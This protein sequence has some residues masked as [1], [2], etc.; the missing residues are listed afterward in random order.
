M[1]LRV[2]RHPRGHVASCNG[3][4]HAV[5]VRIDHCSRQPIS[6]TELASFAETATVKENELRAAKLAH[7]QERVKSR[8]HNREKAKQ[9]EMAV[10]SRK[11][12]QLEQRVTDQAVDGDRI[13]VGREIL[14]SVCVSC[15]YNLQVYKS[16]DVAPDVE[17][18]RVMASARQHAMARQSLS[19]Q[20]ARRSLLE[21][22][23]A[24]GGVTPGED[25]SQSEFR[26]LGQEE[27]VKTVN[28]PSVPGSQDQHC[29]SAV[30]KFT[31]PMQI[32]LARKKQA[33]MQYLVF[34]RLYS[35]LEREQT[36]QRLLRK[37]HYK[38]V[39][40]LKR[41]KEASRRAVEDEADPMDSFSTVSSD[42]LGDEQKAEEWL[43][44]MALE[45]RKQQL[46]RAKEMERYTAAL[47]QRLREK[48]ATQHSLLPPLCSC[49]STLW[50]TDPDTC[51]NNCVFYKN[52]KG[53]AAISGYNLFT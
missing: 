17:D 27:T 45:E 22:R 10:T 49:A 36:R 15:F 11:T 31:A 13:K 40:Q 30:R 38:T 41:Q 8:V 42:A 44:L 2:G 18:I 12:V 24:I 48:L 1:S 47:K 46:Q 35:D 25:F 4:I 28:A 33:G 6:A 43:Q 19:T 37:T 20:T 26:Y 34:R 39:E 7:F 5:A 3:D 21:Q 32:E 51:A 50:D 9:K 14:L 23:A 53:L 29:T 16:V 52:P